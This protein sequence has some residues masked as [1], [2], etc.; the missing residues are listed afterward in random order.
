MVVNPHE[1]A[2]FAEFEGLKYVFVD[3]GLWISVNY[4]VIFYKSL[5]VI[6]TTFNKF[7]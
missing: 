3:N 5:A 6:L 1:A 4:I 2:K 7:R